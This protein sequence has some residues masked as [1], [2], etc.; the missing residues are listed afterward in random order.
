[1]LPYWR[2]LESFGGS[3]MDSTNKDFSPDD[4]I[5]EKV[6]LDDDDI[7]SEL[8]LIE[9]PPENEVDFGADDAGKALLDKEGIFDEQIPPPQATR[10][11]MPRSDG[12][13]KD[14]SSDVR[15]GETAKVTGNIQRLRFYRWKMIAVYSVATLCAVAAGWG[16]TLFVAPFFADHP[17]IESPS[18]A[19]SSVDA[20]SAVLESVQNFD[21]EPFILP[22]HDVNNDP[23]LLRITIRL[24]TSMPH[25]SH[26]QDTIADIRRA[27]YMVLKQQTASDFFNS[28]RTDQIGNEIL[29]IV[30]QTLHATRVY[31]VA[32][33]DIRAV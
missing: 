33:I 25:P 20:S 5:D 30:N 14:D 21:L 31:E 26:L 6:K 29:H 18:N 3:I 10:S 9:V 1:M 17:E 4:P 8:G 16:L 32:F 22:L 24:R 15:P 28:T 19:E 13:R 27:A 23:V 11:P 12:G 2:L 7:L